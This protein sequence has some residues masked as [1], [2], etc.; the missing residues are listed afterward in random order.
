MKETWP[1]IREKLVQNQKVYLLVVIDKQG[2]SPGKPG[3]K[4]AVGEDGELKGSVGGGETEYRLSEMAKKLLKTTETKIFLKHEI[5]KSDA[6]EDRS[7]MICSGEQWVA[8]YPLNKND[9]LLINTIEHAIET[10]QK[11]MLHFNQNGILFNKDQQRH[12]QHKNPVTSLL[13]WEFSEETGNQDNLYIFG[14]GHVGL[15]LSNIMRHLDFAVHIFDDRKGLP[16][17]A[18]NTFVNKSEII[19]Y[20]NIGHLVGEG[21]NNFVVIMTF[22]HKSDEVVLRQLINKKLRY[23]GMMGSRKK[24]K[25]IHSNLLEDGFSEEQIQKVRAPI[26]IPINSQTPYEI[27][28]SIAAQIIAEKNKNISSNIS[29]PS[30]VSAPKY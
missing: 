15:A 1:F 9:L 18:E 21:G 23:L 10:G 20:K 7:G 25:S 4:M 30:L 11:G 8:F 19:N 6:D 26:G 12:H 27:A 17:L 29:S 5:H 16:T 24:V 3:F 13:E 22:G 14:A 2:S 28:I